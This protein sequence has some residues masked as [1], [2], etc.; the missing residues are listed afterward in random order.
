MIEGDGVSAIAVSQDTT[1]GDAISIPGATQVLEPL[2]QRF[3]PPG[4]HSDDDG[5]KRMLDA[6][7]GY[8]PIHGLRGFFGDAGTDE[9]IDSFVA[10]LKRLQ[11]SSH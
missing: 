2:L 11:Q 3:L 7:I 9:L 10:D 1:F 5:M 8:M 6:T 4:M